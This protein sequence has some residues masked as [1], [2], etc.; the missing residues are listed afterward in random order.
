MSNKH[1]HTNQRIDCAVNRQLK[2]VKKDNGLKNISKTILFLVDFYDK[3]K[4]VK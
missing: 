1:S 4:G 3:H 2:A